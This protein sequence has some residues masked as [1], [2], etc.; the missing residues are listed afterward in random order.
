MREKLK[1]IS[2]SGDRI[3]LKGLAPPA[4]ENDSDGGGLGVSV[5]DV[6]KLMRVSLFEKVKKKLREV[7]V[8]SVSHEEFVGFCVEECGSE[9]KGA[10]FAKELDQSGNVVVLGNVVFLR[11][12]QVN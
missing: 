2:I 9:E 7:K 10:E 11:P 6:R 4:P 5:E 12:D 3:Q 8:S 1:G